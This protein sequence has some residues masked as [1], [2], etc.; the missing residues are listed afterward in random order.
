ML[1]P[2]NV[3]PVNARETL[4]RYLI[5][6]SHV[7]R[8]D[9]SVKPDAFI[10]FSRVELSVTRHRDAIEDELWREGR[11]VATIRGTTLY[12]RADVAALAFIAE[13]LAVES[14]PILPENPNHAD[15]V[16]WPADKPAQKMKAIEIA[17]QA[18]FRP[19]PGD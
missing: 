7:R 10:P 4:A 17:R 16:N 1:D 11:R 18:Q 12:G 6:S 14:K 5:A 9:N 2:A 3:P 8:S 19:A 13:S 15:V